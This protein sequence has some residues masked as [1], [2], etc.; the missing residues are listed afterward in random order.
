MVTIYDVAKSAGVSPKTVSRVL[1][2]EARVRETTRQAVHE[3]MAQLDYVPSS[4]ARTMRSNRS[5]LIGLVSS[6]LTSGYERPDQIGL[7][8]LLLV[9]AIQQRL[10]PTGMTLLMADSGGRPERVTALLRTFAE[11][12]VEGLFYV[13]PY[14]QELELPQTPG[15]PHT[16]CVNGF[17]TGTTPA[18]VPDDYAGQRA[19]VEALIERGHRRI[20]YL[21]LPPSYIAT[22]KRTQA[23]RDALSTA[24]LSDDPTLLRAGDADQPSAT[25][26]S[27]LQEDAVDHFLSL[28]DPPTVICTGNDRMAMRL[29]GLLRSRGLRIP[30]DISVVGYDDYRLISETLFPA[31]TTVEL[32]YRQMGEQ[33]ADLLLARINEQA[34]PQSETT[35]QTL[36]IEG[37]LRWRDSVAT[38]IQPQEEPIP[39][40][41]KTR[42]NR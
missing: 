7:P 12:Q 37:A 40:S 22:H 8:D 19:L 31:L 29:Y 26:E 11:H 17:E 24:G 30:E 1:N 38:L 23:W 42:K 18:V 14:H 15:I 27:T 13:A 35:M 20:A 33:A 4:A 16:V 6:A 34:E 3:A 2:G 10:E 5:G 28:P 9:Q 41:P 21:T 32:P 39:E 36:C 25:P